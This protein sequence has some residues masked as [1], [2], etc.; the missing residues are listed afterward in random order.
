MATP[1]PGERI[2]SIAARK[3]LTARRAGQIIALFTVAVT[4]LS[5]VAMWLFDN[6]EYPNLGVAMWWAIQTVT[7]IGYGDVTP[8]EPIGRIIAAVVML[9]GIGFLTVVTA[10]ITAV[11][12]ESARRRLTEEASPG[13]VTLAHLEE[14][15]GRIEAMLAEHRPTGS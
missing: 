9:S 15:L 1:A 4:L 12:I 2:I 7:T 5:G 11:F 13:Q 3:P 6:D 8:E 10:S 14:R